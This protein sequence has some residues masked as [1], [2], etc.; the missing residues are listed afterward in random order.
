MPTLSPEQLTGK[1]RTH[2]LELQEAGCTLQSDAAR[3]Y[4]AL[5]AAAL[6]DGIAVAAASSFRP[7]EHQLSIWNDKFLGRRALLDRDGRAL[8]R[9]QMAETQIVHAILQW[10]ALPG[11]SRHHWGTEI[12]VFDRN[13]LPSGKPMLLPAEFAPGGLFSALDRWLQQHAERFGF[14]R[15]YDRDR[16]GVAP[17]PWHLSFAPVSGPALQTLRLEVLAE[18][19]SS[20]D[21]AGATVVRSQLADIYERYVLAVATP[22]PQALAARSVGSEH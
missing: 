19:L 3:A 16:G 1:A 20:V 15:P 11:A 14:F 5:R 22:P 4:L 12:D 10:S 7:F 17:E 13:T 21:L 18:A 8:D 9:T 2:V 6:R